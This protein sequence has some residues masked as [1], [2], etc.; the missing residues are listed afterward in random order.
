MERDYS[1]LSNEDLELIIKDGLQSEFWKW[2]KTGFEEGQ[3]EIVNQLIT[4]RLTS[5]DDVVKIVDLISRHKARS[6]VYS[7]PEIA[8]GVINTEKENKSRLD[9]DRR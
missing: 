3:T 5:W 7:M 1:N 8:L 9:S 6:L 2:F 4:M